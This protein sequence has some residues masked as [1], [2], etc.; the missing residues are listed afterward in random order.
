MVPL[1][2]LIWVWET[3]DIATLA[4]DDYMLAS[5]SSTYLQRRFQTSS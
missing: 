1:Y 4:S 3:W 5:V 2:S